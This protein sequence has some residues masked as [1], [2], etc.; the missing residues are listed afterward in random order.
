MQKISVNSSFSCYRLILVASISLLFSC[1]KDQLVILPPTSSAFTLRD[2]LTINPQY[3]TGPFSNEYNRYN[4]KSY[5]VNSNNKVK[6]SVQKAENDIQFYFVD[7]SVANLYPSFSITI[8]NTQF[9]NIAAQYSLTNDLA[10]AVTT[11]QTFTDGSTAISRVN[12]QLSW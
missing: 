5:N 1:K 7:S 3:Q 8:K 10:V 2:T 11:T 6:F 4:G 12:G 9:D